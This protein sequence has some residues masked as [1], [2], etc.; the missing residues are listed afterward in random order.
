M[1]LSIS[2]PGYGPGLLYGIRH[3][4]KALSEVVMLGDLSGGV[5]FGGCLKR[6]GLTINSAVQLPR[7]G[8]LRRRINRTLFMISSQIT[9]VNFGSIRNSELRYW[10]FL[11]INSAYGRLQPLYRWHG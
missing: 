5:F 9:I 6:F 7:S 3:R 10:W 1:N 4:M 11:L 2:G 8:K